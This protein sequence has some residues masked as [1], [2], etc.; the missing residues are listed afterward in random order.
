MGRYRFH[1]DSLPDSFAEESS[2]LRGSLTRLLRAALNQKF[3][4]NPTINVIAPS[5]LERASRPRHQSQQRISAVNGG[6]RRKD[7]RYNPPDRL[8]G[9][10]CHD[11]R[12]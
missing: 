5:A 4:A 6:V 9:R 12:P 2:N 7:L 11:S 3:V 1:R 8:P 10:G